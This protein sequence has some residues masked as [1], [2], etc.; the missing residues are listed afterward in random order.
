[1]FEIAGF[2]GGERDIIN[3]VLN[4]RYYYVN[5]LGSDLVQILRNRWA[6]ERQDAL[7]ML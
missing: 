1:M 3:R 6:N 4:K 5:G 2:Y 7:N